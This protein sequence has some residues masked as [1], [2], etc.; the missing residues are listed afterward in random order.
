MVLLC[1]GVLNGSLGALFYPPNEVK[2][3][4]AAWNG[5]PITVGHPEQSG[6]DPSVLNDRGIGYVFRT[7]YRDGRLVAEGW[8][9]VEHTKR[10]DHRVFD[11]LTKGRPIELSTGLYTENQPAARGST[12]N[13]KPYDYIARHYRPDHLAILP[14]AIGACSVSDGCGV[15][16]SVDRRRRPALYG[17]DEMV[18]EYD[19][20]DDDDDDLLIPPRMTFG[21][22]RASR[23][24]N[25]H[26]C[27]CQ[28]QNRRT[29]NPDA[30]PLAPCAQA[31]R[32]LD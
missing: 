2:R 6:R 30:V 16:V 7:E 9:D 24:Q 15:N 20:Y 29:E 4:P 18:P 25:T 8:F 21:P 22:P 14:D 19:D 5:V 12:Y 1:P 11:A 27:G 10:T 3:H 28:T 13:G 17:D 26:K 23:T 31:M 32:D